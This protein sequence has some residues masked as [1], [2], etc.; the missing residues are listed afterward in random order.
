MKTISKVAFLA[1]SLFAA[2]VVF[3]QAQPAANM[4]IGNATAHD[5]QAA[6]NDKFAELVTKYSKG[7]IKA[8][9]RH[10]GS[11]G[12]YSQMFAAMQ[13]GSVNGMITVAGLMSTLVPEL[14]LFN[15]PFLLSNTAPAKITAF[16]AQSKAAA[17]MMQ[18]AEEKGIHIIGF[19]GI[20]P[21]DLLTKF[22]VNKLA[23]IQ[24]KKIWVISSP[25]ILGAYQ[26]WNAV[27][28]SMPIGEGYTS[29][30]QG[31]V[32]GLELPPDVLYRMKFHE[33]AKYYTII[34]DSVFVSAVFVSKKWLDGLPKGLQNAVTRAGKDTIVF[35][36]DAYTKSQNSS[37]DALRKAI[38]VTNMPAAEIQKMKDLVQQGIWERMRNDPQK[39][40]MLKLLEE[41]VARFNKT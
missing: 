41:D 20:G 29:L 13:A 30:Q 26:D 22:P 32:Q 9:A 36:D 8:S 33:V 37:L 35:A 34:E 16:A 27:T 28:R 38:T 2:N 5:T 21:Q 3:G 39:S 23:D 18:L 17:K 1:A 4:L 10:G 24:G 25:P 7:R 19:H 6:A 11:L 40:P 15:M 31:L 12:S 14:S